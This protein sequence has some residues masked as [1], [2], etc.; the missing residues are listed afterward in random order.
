MPKLNFQHVLSFLLGSIGL[1]P[2]ICLGF[3]PL[4]NIF[5]GNNISTAYLLL[6]WGPFGLSCIVMGFLI[7]KVK[8]SRKYLCF[9]YVIWGFLII[10]L[11]YVIPNLTLILILVVLLAIV[12]AVN[13]IIASSYLS[14]HAK[15]NRRGF[16]TAFYLGIGWIIVAGGAYISFLNLFLNLALLAILSIIAGLGS[17]LI[18]N[19]GKAK[20]TWEQR[21][22]IPRNYDVK[23]NGF[24]FYFSTL[25]FG[26][27]LGIIIY[28]LGTYPS[29]EVLVLFQDSVYLGNLN[30][31]YD[32]V[33]EFGFGTSLVNFD[34]LGI[35]AMAAV[36]SP[37]LGKL[38]D[39]TGRKPIFFAA[40]L[41]IPI[42]LVMFPLW[43]IDAFLLL[44]VFLYA[45]VVSVFVVINLS[46][47]T[48]LAP[49]NKI[50]RFNGYG[51]SS[52]GIGG[53]SGFLLGISITSGIIELDL[54]VILAVLIVSE[55]SLIPFVLMKESLPPSD[56]LEW[57]KE[58]IHL[59]VISNSGII[60]SDYSF[61]KTSGID[62]PDLLAGGISGITAILKE[63]VGSD[64]QL[65]SI[66]HAD[67]K[68]LFEYAYD[69]QFL[70]ALLANKDLN[71]LRTKLKKLTAQIQSVFWETI[72]KWDGDLDI[73]APMKTIIRY[74]FVDD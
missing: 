34:F 8:K 36:M 16:S 20:L 3:A 61:T 13:T 73:L 14:S 71:I 49:E 21:I 26:V 19:S 53:A 25:I 67:K 64:Q 40:N 1:M 27:F 42:V 38:I 43:D 66:D 5:E 69:D 59:Y 23:R 33:S 56:E 12:T 28:L 15:M 48:D 17:F 35:G 2:I 45:L 22:V 9:S 51:W 11:I 18:C 58:I 68:L 4:I 30:H 46:V 70:I 47:W 74:H 63:M 32:F 41:A 57:R 72:V 10:G 52:L 6:F 50:A 7:D 37:I 44:S 31:Y 29:A 62:S 60:M 24:V 54:L 55:L 39:K 65:K